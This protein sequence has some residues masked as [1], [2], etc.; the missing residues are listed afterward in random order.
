M[1]TLTLPLAACVLDS[2]PGDLATAT[3]RAALTADE[4]EI[5]SVYFGVDNIVGVIQAAGCPIGS[6]SP[7][8]DGMPIV[9]N[10][11]I[12]QTTHH[13]SD[14]AVTFRNRF[15]SYRTATPACVGLPPADDEPED[16]TVLTAG[17]YGDGLNVERVEI[18]GDVLDEDGRNLQG[19]S[20]D[21]V[22]PFGTGPSLIDAE[23]LA[24]DEWEPLDDAPMTGDEC[25]VG[26]EQIVQ[27]TW[28]GGIT[29]ATNDGE[30]AD[31]E[32]ME[33][34][35]MVITPDGEEIS[36]TPFDLGDLNDGD[37]YNDLC[38]DVAGTPV[39][40][41]MDAGVV[42]DP[43]GFLNLATTIPVL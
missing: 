16:R 10:V 42:S 17:Q 18:V 34:R 35:V 28:Q 26:T 19:L 24:L 21:S 7:I 32:R 5:L 31:E 20:F 25:A 33:Y 1:Y 37:N 2:A 13:A 4:P 40:V 8:Q 6:A 27:V 22:T 36:V 14:I 11:E 43:S 38:L 23:V 9:F 12:D 30:L 3:E 29:N 15:G 41:S 39:E